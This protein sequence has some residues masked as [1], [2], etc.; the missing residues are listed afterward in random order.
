M[1]DQ[2]SRNADS[3]EISA[4]SFE[5]NSKTKEDPVHVPITLCL[6]I[7]A[8]YVCGGGALFSIWEKWN[9]LDGS[10]FCFVTLSKQP[11]EATTFA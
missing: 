11:S 7:L 1:S 3:V 4:M 6:L 9:Y 5:V 10:Y 2:V 8:S